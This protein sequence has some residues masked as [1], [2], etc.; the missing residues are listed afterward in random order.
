KSKNDS[1]NVL[2]ESWE[3]VGR[4]WESA[5][6]NVNLPLSPAG[7]SHSNDAEKNPKLLPSR[8]VTFQIQRS[9]G[10]LWPSPTPPWG[11]GWLL[12]RLANV[13]WILCRGLCRNPRI[14]A[15]ATRCSGK[16]ISACD[17]RGKP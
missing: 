12:D 11:A 2:G 16:C 3:I 17:T 9:G 8:A 13:H 15:H 10:T 1:V 6:R 14:P 4:K 7:F 5:G